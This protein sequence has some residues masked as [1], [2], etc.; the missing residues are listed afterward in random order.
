[1]HA[2]D[3]GKLLAFPLRL[4]QQRITFIWRGGN[5]E[6]HHCEQLWGLVYCTQEH[7]HMKQ[8]SQGSASPFIPLYCTIRKSEGDGYKQATAM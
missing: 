6:R 2:V 5:H 3:D 1:M 4:L 7:F 8:S